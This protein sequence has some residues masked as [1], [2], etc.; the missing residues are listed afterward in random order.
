MINCFTK[1]LKDLSPV[2]SRDTR[3]LS[4]LYIVG[5]IMERSMDCFCLFV[6]I[7]LALKKFNV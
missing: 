4:N 3:F 6:V 1:Y 7:E 5:L 2:V